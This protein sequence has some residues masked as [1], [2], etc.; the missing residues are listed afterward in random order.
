MGGDPTAEASA[1][2]GQGVQGPTPKPSLCWQLRLSSQVQGPPPHPWIPC[3]E[4]KAKRLIFGPQLESVAD[5]DQL[6]RERDLGQIFLSRPQEGALLL[7]P[8]LGS[9][10]EEGRGASTTQGQLLLH[11]P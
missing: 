6:G 5:L 7:G 3:H 11:D 8:S 9:T 4:A 10:R 2:A 1:R